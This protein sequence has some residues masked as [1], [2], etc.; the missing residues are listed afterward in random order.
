MKII[1]CVLRDEPA[2]KDKVVDLAAW[3]AENLIVLDE[4]EAGRESGLGQYGGRELVRRRQRR[5]TAAQNRAELAATLA[6]TAAFLVLIVR[7]LLF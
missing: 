5:S 4:P 3:K 1:N 7:I 6:V 2:G